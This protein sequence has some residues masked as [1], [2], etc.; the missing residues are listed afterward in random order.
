[1]WQNCNFMNSGASTNDPN[2]GNNSQSQYQDDVIIKST[3]SIEFDPF[4]RNIVGPRSC[5]YCGAKTTID[6]DPDKCHRPQLFFG[7]KEPPFSLENDYYYND[8]DKCHR[9]QLFFG[10]KEPPFSLENDYYY[11]D[12]DYDHE[13]EQYHGH[14]HGC[15]TERG[16]RLRRHRQRLRRRGGYNHHNYHHLAASSSWNAR[17]GNM[18]KEH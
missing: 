4:N 11:N 9:P 13:K 8:Y 2:N 10:K 3:S 14:G 5:E 15:D 16:Q 18:M 12:Y 17:Y 1:M 6:C 7:K